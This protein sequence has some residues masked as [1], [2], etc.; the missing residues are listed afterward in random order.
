MNDSM[1]SLTVALDRL[2]DGE[3][4][5]AEYDRLLTMLDHHPEHWRQCALAFIE[6]Q[7]LG[8]ELRIVRSEALVTKKPKVAVAPATS[9]SSNYKVIG[10]AMA[11]SFLAALPVGR[12]IAPPTPVAVPMVVQQP[13]EDVVLTPDT[14]AEA[15][16]SPLG[17]VRLT[18]ED[19][20]ID[21]PYYSLQ[22]GAR[23][24][25]DD[26]SALADSM[27]ESLERAGHHVERS[28]GVMPV[29]LDNGAQVYLPVDSYRITPVSNRSIQ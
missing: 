27:I 21:V 12:Y 17:Q 29:Q 14:V 2:V 4:S 28:P 6:A 26:Q 18:T 8:G 15:S 24:L 25:L 7:A 19:G 3:L 9:R 10:L 13:R 20:P 1:K 16:P 11:A 5:G 22:D 23:Y